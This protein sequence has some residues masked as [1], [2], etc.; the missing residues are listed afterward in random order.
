MSSTVRM[1]YASQA[2]LRRILT[3]ALIALPFLLMG[4]YTLAVGLGWIP[5]DPSRLHV[6]PW[7][8][9]VIGLPFMAV[10]LGILGVP[11]IGELRNVMAMMLIVFVAIINWTAFSDDPLCF[12]RRADHV[13]PRPRHI[14]C[15][16][17]TGAPRLPLIAAALVVDLVVV[18]FVVRDLRRHLKKPG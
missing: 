16:E 18:A 9:A 2:R 11:W 6:P 1:S 13:R 17:D 4:G 14:V 3:R 8:F 5:I 10:G 12:A 15:Q 7:V